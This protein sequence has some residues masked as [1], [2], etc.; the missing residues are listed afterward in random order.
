MENRRKSANSSQARGAVAKM[1]QAPKAVAKIAPA[2]VD[3]PA[4]AL[5]HAEVERKTRETSVTARAPKPLAS[6]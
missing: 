2:K 1:A 5:R 3:R 4:K 6:I